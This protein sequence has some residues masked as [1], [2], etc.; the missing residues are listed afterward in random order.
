MAGAHGPSLHSGVLA[1]TAEQAARA[2]KPLLV[3]L[4]AVAILFLGLA[5]APGAA[6]VGPRLNDVLARHRLELVGLGVVALGGAAIA[7]LH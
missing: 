6:V 7:L 5:S 1:S 2:A 4:L 3:A